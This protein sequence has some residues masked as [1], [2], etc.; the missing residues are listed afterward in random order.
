M[1]VSEHQDHSVVN[2]DALKE[3]AVDDSRKKMLKLLCFDTDAV[4]AIVELKRWQ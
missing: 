2:C 4:D 1:L 3:V